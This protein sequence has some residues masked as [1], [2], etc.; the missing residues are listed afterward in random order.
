[1]MW[2][3]SQVRREYHQIA[4]QH[5]QMVS[6]YYRLHPDPDDQPGPR[7]YQMRDLL[8][9]DENFMQLELRE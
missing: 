8:D 7:Q 5:T 6:H 2:R 1:M 4:R 9:Q 3:P